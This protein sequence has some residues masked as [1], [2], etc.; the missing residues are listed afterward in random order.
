M[1]VRMRSRMFEMMVHARRR[2]HAPSEREMSRGR[3]PAMNRRYTETCSGSAP[4]S[5]GWS[6]SSVSLASGWGLVIAMVMAEV[7][8]E[9]RET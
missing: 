9:K 5:A 7:L 4:M 1:A 2:L 8:G 6:A 3:S